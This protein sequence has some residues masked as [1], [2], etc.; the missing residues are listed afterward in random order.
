MKLEHDCVRDILIWVENNVPIGNPRYTDDL[1]DEMKDKWGKGEVI[2][3]VALLDE[4]SLLDGGAVIQGGTI[5]INQIN[6]GRPQILR[7]YS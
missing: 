6:M 2:Y 7:Q 5:V 1:I 3:C 4:A